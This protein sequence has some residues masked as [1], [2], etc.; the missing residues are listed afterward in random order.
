KRRRLFGMERA[1]PFMLLAGSFQDDN[2]GDD[3]EQIGSAPDFSDY[4]GGYAFQ[5]ILSSP[6]QP[7]NS[8]HQP[9][10]TGPI[11]VSNA[12]DSAPQPRGA[13]CFIART[14]GSTG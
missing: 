11:S 2:F 12:G 3:L 8:K 5:R 1:Q 4:F 9:G 6:A 10:K 14:A 13:P 7:G